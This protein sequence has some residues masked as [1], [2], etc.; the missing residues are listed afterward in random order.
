MNTRF[1]IELQPGD[2]LPLERATG[3]RLTSLEGSLWVTEEG[4]PGDIVLAPGQSFA[5]EAKGRALVQALSRARVAIEA[6]NKRALVGFGSVYQD[7]L[8]A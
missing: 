6:A 8:A 2:V 1:V 5:V 7:K 3:V 4:E